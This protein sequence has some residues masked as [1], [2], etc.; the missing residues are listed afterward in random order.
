MVPTKI[1]VVLLAKKFFSVSLSK[2]DFNF[3]NCNPSLP[4]CI[5][6]SLQ[7]NNHFASFT[8]LNLWYTLYNFGL[9]C[10]HSIVEEGSR[11]K[12]RKSIRDNY[13]PALFHLSQD[14]GHAI[15]QGC[16][17]ELL[18]VSISLFLTICLIECY[19]VIILFELMNH[20]YDFAKIF[21]V[22]TNALILQD[23]RW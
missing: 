1:L 23:Q 14:M 7:K 10:T 13:G 12:V 9:K 3:T 4:S 22:D 2:Q 18:Y 20:N 17:E 21:T 16:L 11:N 6:F 15:M 19:N 8:S 5:Q